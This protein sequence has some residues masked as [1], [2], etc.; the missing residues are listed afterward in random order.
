MAEA[1]IRDQLKILGNLG[2]GAGN[3]ILTRDPV[4]KLV[5]EVPPIDPSTYLS[6]TLPQGYLLVGNASNI[7]TPVALSGAIS[8]TPA[9][10]TS[11]A[12][13]YISNVHI[14]SGAAISYS[15]LN[16]SGAIVNNDI[17]TAAAISRSKL[18]SGNANRLLIN[19]GAGV[20]ADNAALTINRVLVSD[21]NGL[22]VASAM[23]AANLLFLDTGATSLTTLLSNKLEFSSGIT[24]AN[25]DM[26]YF[27]TVWTNLGIGTAGQVLT[28]SG[29]G[30]PVWGSAAANG[31]PTGGTAGQYLRKSSGTN[32]DAAFASILTTEISG[33]TASS[34][35]LN[36]LSGAYVAGLTAAE[37]LYVNGVTSAIQSQIDL[38]LDRTLTQ[39][40]MFVGNVSNVATPMATGANGYVLTSVGGV[41]TWVAPGAGGTVTSVQVSGGT[42]G[43]SATGGPITTSGTITL[44]GTLIAANGGTGF[45]SYAVG[46][47]LYANTTTTL[48]KL[49]AGTATYVLTS[50]GAGVAPSW[51]A[52]PV[53]G[54]VIENDGTPLT[55]RANL[56]FKNGL[57]ASD[58]TPDTEVQL[59]G[60]LTALV[61]ITTSAFDM[62]IGDVTGAYFD[63]TNGSVALVTD[64]GQLDF[65]AGDIAGAFV[66]TDNRTTKQGIK[67]AAAGYVTDARSL[68][69]KGYAD[70]TY[71]PITGGTYWSLDTGGTLTGANTF[72]INS[73]NWLNFT[74][75]WTAT[76]NNQY[77]ARFGGTLTAR[78]TVSDFLHGYIFN[79]SLT[80]GATGQQDILAVTIQPTLVGGAD[81][82]DRSVALYVNPTFSGTFN[83]RYGIVSTTASSTSYGGL[84]IMNSSTGS[85]VFD[86]VA[87]N[88]A[89]LG[90]ASNFY[91]ERLNGANGNVS[92]TNTGTGN[93]VLT[94]NASTYTL[95]SGA[96]SISQESYGLLLNTQGILSIATSSMQMYYSSTTAGNLQV[97]SSSAGV[98]ISTG[99]LSSSWKPALYVAPGAHTSMTAN[100]EF[101]SNDFQGA[102]QQWLAGTVATQRFNYFRGFTVTGASATATFT[103][104]YTVYIE[105]PVAGTNATITNSYALGINGGINFLDGNGSNGVRI[106]REQ[107]ANGAFKITQVGTGGIDI[108]MGTF[109]NS[110]LVI[111][112]GGSAMYGISNSGYLYAVSGNRVHFGGTTHTNAHFE[113]TIFGQTSSHL[114]AGIRFN[115]GAHT[116]IPNT[117]EAPI[118]FDFGGTTITQTW[119][120]GGTVAIQRQAYFRGRTLA[121]ATAQ[122]FTN[123]YTLY[124]DPPVAGT[125]A[126]ITRNWAAYFNG[127]MGANSFSIPSNS[128]FNTIQGYAS[129]YGMIFDMLD[130]SATNG[131]FFRQQAGDGAATRIFQLG[132]SS[133]N[134]RW[135]P[136]SGS[137][138][139][140]GF[141][142]STSVELTSGT[143]SGNIYQYYVGGAVNVSITYSGNI[144]GYSYT[145]TY[146]ITGGTPNLKGFYYGPAITA[147]GSA[148]HYA[149]HS[150][151]G[152]IL[153]AGTLTTADT[154]ATLTSG[155][156]LD[157]RSAA[158]GALIV[159]NAAGTTTLLDIPEGGARLVSS[160]NGLQILTNGGGVGGITLNGTGAVSNNIIVTAGFSLWN[161]NSNYGGAFNI[162]LS[163]GSGAGSA[164]SGTQAGIK[165]RGNFVG[166]STAAFNLLT[167]NTDSV[168]NAAATG[169]VN[170][171]NLT[172]TYTLAGGLARG[173]YYNPTT[174][175]N[176]TGAH[177]S[178]EATAGTMLLPASVTGR[179]PLR[180]PHGTAPSSPVDGDIWTTTTSIYARINGSTIDLGG[181][182]GI[183]NG[184]AANEMMK[185]DG[186]NAVASGIFSTVAGDVT[187]GTG[188][189]GATRTIT[190]TGTATNVGLV[191]AT[192]G[193]GTLATPALT[194]L[195][196][197]S[198]SGDRTLQAVSSDTNS[199]IE[200]ISKGTGSIRL[201]NALVHLG[202]TAL[203]GSDRTITA[204][205]SATDINIVLTPKGTGFVDIASGASFRVNGGT[206][207]ITYSQASTN[208][209]LNLLQ[210][211]RQT[212]GTPAVGIGVGILLTTQ[213]FNGSVIESVA[214]DLTGASED[215]DLLFKNMAGGAAAAERLRIKSTGQLQ[216]ANYTASGSFTGTPV[217]YLQFDASGNIITAAVPSGGGNV[218][219]TGT[220]ADNQ[221]AVW[222]TST[223]IEGTANLTFDG[224]TFTVNGGTIVGSATTQNVFNTNATTVNFAGAATTFTTGGTPTGALTATIFGN[225]TAAATKTINIGTGSGSTS[226]T[227]INIGTGSTGTAVN[228]TIGTSTLGTTQING[229]TTSIAST[230]VTMSAATTVNVNGASPSFVSTS[231]G[232][233]TFFN[234]NLLT[235][236]QFGAATTFTMGGTPTGA[237]TANFFNNATSGATKTIN[238]GTSGGATST[239]AIN[240]GTGST[241]TAVNVTIGTGTIGTTQI[242]GATTSIAST[243]VTMSAAT[244]INVNGASPSFVST[245]TGTLTFFN[246]NIVTVSAWGAA[247]T[248]TIGATTGTLNLRNA[249]IVL[250]QTPATDASFSTGTILVRD[251]SGNLDK[252]VASGGGT[253][254]F[255]RADGTWAAPPNPVGI[256]DMW[257]PATAMYPKTTGG[258][259]AATQIELATSLVNL[260]CLQLTS[261][262]ADENV[263]FVVAMPRNWNNGTITF[264][265]HWTATSGTGTVRWAL[266][267]AAYSNDDLMT[268]SNWGTAV[269]VDDALTVVNDLHVADRS[270]AVTVGGTPADEDLVIFELTR[271]G[272]NAADTFSGTAMLIGISLA[273][274]T[275][276]A[277][278][279]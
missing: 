224:T 151:S 77:M 243:T 192:K 63:A 103:N 135:Q 271:V 41:P 217:G 171:L 178:F 115:A 56:N 184:A 216:L 190:A 205:G 174:P 183:T 262:T 6:T 126:T 215:F 37:L 118:D 97:G 249:T 258:S 47:I 268:T 254:N 93:I 85:A 132:L 74:G 220:P 120:G 170:I 40:Y 109:G 124:V 229:G 191:L 194:D 86:M 240:I 75:T 245:S 148:V 164:S 206:Q 228:V 141:Y 186:T 94:A 226:T 211:T 106:V 230:T 145:P 133:V 27:N 15:K 177:Y 13:D 43:L 152:G 142:N 26:I 57:T 24:P 167:V 8:I 238:I 267:A 36:I 204:L 50:N 139:R 165:F 200:I 278:A 255:L 253:T 66:F 111:R 266:R 155:Y 154:S 89:S 79:P 277:T 29:G 38:K 272:S 218:S 116:N 247:T 104:V 236:T 100:T 251:A 166:T 202:N 269:A 3:P 55:A 130:T 153:L 35:D 1:I 232:T 91:I 237:I 182:G 30:L 71:A 92:I 140:W 12:N 21:G 261:T 149:F 99:A 181:G 28:V 87:S 212:S 25:G 18:A 256:Q 16:L 161:P 73:A 105:P 67:Y 7:A 20:M 114:P 58:N 17:A 22:P 275:D 193:T 137:T 195:G 248:V 242:N 123:A 210:L 273:I 5:K 19:D 11:I 185:S 136:T 53:S 48:A 117:A 276:A 14:N 189:A 252:I 196:T 172:P 270:A 76:A 157:V 163:S 128:V 45:A 227:A 179:A 250:T 188:L 219:N 241:G 203:A 138:D 244:T 81:N 279:A 223:V 65:V 96:T 234:T 80:G 113:V 169:D 112:S 64:F 62:R 23:T 235:V 198:I 90:T 10:L 39:N 108:T 214:T 143:F 51:Q 122:T 263:Q 32:Y 59:G 70:A 199:T 33:V 150:T 88:S 265:V 119:V 197:A 69:D 213:S 239:V 160:A 158:T 95:K 127:A 222:T 110:G 52:V 176:I 82:T 4:T 84:R 264:R 175:G 101:I 131:F 246:T 168:I 159:K 146:N 233:L 44:S 42:T 129:G 2:S 180:I 259:G 125:N 98:L 144:A 134:N 201:V 34:D 78:T 173:I 225:A 68:V 31:L 274:T 147:I 207:S 156:K 162:E 260:Q 209:V 257:I 187:L 121:G 54:H 208:T 221:I 9:G 46:D 49:T 102:S 83:S 72:T 60:T 107:G 231:T 61:T